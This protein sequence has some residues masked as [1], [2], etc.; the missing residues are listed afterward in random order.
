MQRRSSAR[1]LALIATALVGLA[2]AS[3]H[4]KTVQGTGTTIV[5]TVGGTVAPFIVP[6]ATLPPAVVGG[7]S[8]GTP[9]AAPPADDGTEG[10]PSEEFTAP[11]SNSTQTT[12]AERDIEPAQA[13]ATTSTVAGPTPTTRLTHS[14]V[15][16]PALPPSGSEPVGPSVASRAPTTTT[17][18]RPTTTVATTT[19][20]T[21]VATTT[22]ASPSTTRGA[23]API[24]PTMAT[25]NQ[26]IRALAKDALRTF[27]I[28]GG[29]AV[30]TLRAD[31]R[32]LADTIRRRYGSRVRTVLG[33]FAYPA[34]SSK[35]QDR[36]EEAYCAPVP[37]AGRSNTSLKWTARPS[38]MKVKSGADLTV[39]VTFS[40]ISSATVRFQSG[41]PITGIVTLA[42]TTKTVATYDGYL[43]TII[44]TGTLRPREQ[45]RVSAT[46]STASCRRQLGWALPPGTYDVRFAFGGY[47][48]TARGGAKVDQ[49]VSSPLPLV[50]N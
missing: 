39:D 24:A 30:V 34:T 1:L 9:K 19:T 44:R 46:I 2:S 49:F 26:E 40:N 14:A 22:T 18:K 23:A 31:Q 48:L 29:A 7:S 21:R 16:G 10:E 6:P 5:P 12:S 13:P 36:D 25:L 50:V 3:V 27:A 47:D 38:V 11:P 45:A 4:A 35:N 20:T 15:A 42:G 33:H 17:A 32:T 43:A 37:R 8:A 28:D 41:D